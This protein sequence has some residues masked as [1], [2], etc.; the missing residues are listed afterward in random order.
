MWFN[1]ECNLLVADDA[2]ASTLR[3][4]FEADL[5]QAREITWSD[6]KHRPWYSRL[7]D[8]SARSLRVLL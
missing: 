8:L 4:H 3:E 6:W 5:A 7:G 2:T 1:A